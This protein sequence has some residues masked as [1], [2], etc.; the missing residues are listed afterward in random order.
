M[1]F[2]WNIFLDKFWKEIYFTTFLTYDL[3]HISPVLGGVILPPDNSIIVFRHFTRINS[4]IDI[5]ETLHLR[6]CSSWISDHMDQRRIILRKLPEHFSFLIHC[7][8]LQE[9]PFLSLLNTVIF[10]V[11]LTQT[12]SVSHWLTPDK[13]KQGGEADKRGAG[14]LSISTQIYLLI[15]LS[16]IFWCYQ[17]ESIV[18]VFSN[19]DDDDV[20]RTIL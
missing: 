15:H 3:L 16:V 11:T 10:T 9:G 8:S 6:A 7:S 4:N 5:T 2:V 20:K 19:N 18:Q 1:Y 14:H 17:T 12:W 13:R